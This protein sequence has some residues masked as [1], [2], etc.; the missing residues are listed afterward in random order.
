MF[1]VGDVIV[2]SADTTVIAQWQLPEAEEA[3]ETVG[4]CLDKAEA[5][6]SD[7]AEARDGYYAFVCEKCASAFRYHGRFAFASE[8]EKRAEEIYAGA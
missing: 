5:L 7:P 3:E 1:N 8:L 4:D 2:V 6:L